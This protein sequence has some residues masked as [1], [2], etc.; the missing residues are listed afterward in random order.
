MSDR[1]D[2]IFVVCDVYLTIT[3]ETKKT[4]SQQNILNNHIDGLFDTAFKYVGQN[5]RIILM[6][7][8]GIE[9]AYTGSPDEA[10]KLAN[11][12]VN[13]I[14]MANKKGEVPLSV[15]ISIHLEPIQETNFFKEYSNIIAT[16]IHAATQ[17]M[18]KAKH[19][20][21]LA[22]R[23][24][25][26][27]I[28]LSNQALLALVDHPRAKQDVALQCDAYL[29]DLDKNQIVQ[30]QLLIFEQPITAVETLPPPEK[31]NFL[32]L[33][34][35]NYLVASLFILVGLFSL[36]FLGGLFSIIKLATVPTEP[37]TQ[38]TKTLPLDSLSAKPN[39]PQ[40]N[41][42]V[43]N[44]QLNQEKLTP[45]DSAES[46]P[47]KKIVARQSKRKADNNLKNNHSKEIL[48]W[49]IFKKSIKQGKKNECTQSEKALNQCR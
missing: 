27:N 29:A 22:S 26:D 37:Q 47:T 18:H 8:K 34:A 31:T 11:D 4:D 42:N 6:T 13:G 15:R 3:D 32:N 17:I 40:K 49:E 41:L 16:G 43:Y 21:I 36:F 14:V 28:S 35:W 25:F 33:S 44:H 45:N 30:N 5:N 19:N 2:M 38:V 23:A 48:N 20:Q 12:I 9:I 1:F 46:T 7:N 39:L 24:Y 10:A